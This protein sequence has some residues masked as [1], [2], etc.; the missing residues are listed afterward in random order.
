MSST[1]IDIRV[2]SPKINIY[3]Y[4]YKGEGEY[5]KTA[6]EKYNNRKIN[7]YLIPSIN[8]WWINNTEFEEIKL[9]MSASSNLREEIC[10][11]KLRRHILKSNN[12]ILNP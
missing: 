10:Q 9:M 1:C 7:T 4:I 8:T 6:L 5:I 11:L 3:I 12:T 2:K